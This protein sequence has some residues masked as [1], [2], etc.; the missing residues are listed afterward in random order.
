[1]VVTP[2]NVI[3]SVASLLLALSGSG[4]L[5]LAD[6]QM[7]G[8]LSTTI[9]NADTWP[10]GDHWISM[11][12]D[13]CDRYYLRI[14]VGGKFWSVYITNP[15]GCDCCPGCCSTNPF[16]AFPWPLRG[17]APMTLRFFDTDK[18]KNDLLQTRHNSPTTFNHLAGG[19]TLAQALD[20]T[21]VSPRMRVEVHITPIETTL[22]VHD[23]TVVFTNFGVVPSQV[24]DNRFDVKMNADNYQNGMGL[25]T[26]YFGRWTGIVVG[27][28]N[29][30]MHWR[31]RR[32]GLIPPNIFYWWHN[33][34]IGYSIRTSTLSQGWQTVPTFGTYNPYYC[35]AGSCP[36]SRTFTMT[37]R[38]FETYREYTATLLVSRAALQAAMPNEGDWIDMQSNVTGSYHAFGVRVAWM[39]ISREAIDS[40]TMAR[41]FYGIYL[42]QPFNLQDVLV[43]IYDNHD[44]HIIFRDIETHFPYRDPSRQDG[45][46]GWPLALDFWTR[47]AEAAPRNQVFRI[48]I[49]YNRRAKIANNLENQVRAILLQ[50]WARDEGGDVDNVI[51]PIPPTVLNKPELM[52]AVAAKPFVTNEVVLSLERNAT[53]TG[54]AAM[55][56]LNATYWNRLMDDDRWNH[57][58]YTFYNGTRHERDAL[59]M[60]LQSCLQQPDPRLLWSTN[61]FV[62]LNSFFPTKPLDLPLF[63]DDATIEKLFGFS[64]V[65]RILRDR[66]EQWTYE[67]EIIC[68]NILFFRRHVSLERWLYTRAYIIRNAVD[69]GLR[70]QDYF[71]VPVENIFRRRANTNCRFVYNSSTERLQ[72]LAS[73]PIALHEELSMDQGAA[74]MSKIDYLIRYGQMHPLAA[75][76]ATLPDAD[77]FLL[78]TDFRRWEISI[79]FM[80]KYKISWV[81]ATDMTKKKIEDKLKDFPTSVDGL[82]SS[83]E[84]VNMAMELLAMERDVLE[85]NKGRA[86]NDHEAA[87]A[88]AAAA[89]ALP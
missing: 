84:M 70:E 55:R 66:L 89:A 57:T 37:L 48:E 87:K 20:A 12:G 74:T 13:G 3:L 34:Q 30:E 21:L 54:I 81:A 17:L 61:Y 75:N 5:L 27:S 52:G 47:R 62:L 8:T 56:W 14:T 23:G 69:I 9:W 2:L 25:Q 82:G 7:T 49:K 72:V 39:N 35:F 67:Y 33:S 10:A 4:I 31:W 73:K 15:Y 44:N 41:Q 28:G 71:I 65:A 43:Y 88:A 60:T 32:K 51:V 58:W 63:W 19:V 79:G 6:A 40:P 42:L 26:H 16:G 85:W 11:N 22:L 68:D 50:D 18:G 1:M 29:P 45:Q 38:F 80:R 77:L 86:N 78:K 64:E 24:Q 76:A 59:A 46:Y 83:T 53:I 36:G